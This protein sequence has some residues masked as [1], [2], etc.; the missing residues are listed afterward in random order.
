MENSKST[1]LRRDP[2][3]AG[4]K[5]VGAPPGLRSAQRSGASSNRD[6]GG[7]AGGQRGGPQP[8]QAED[9]RGLSNPPIRMADRL[10]SP[11]RRAAPRTG[12]GVRVRGRSRPHDRETRQVMAKK[13]SRSR[14]STGITARLMLLAITGYQRLLS[15]FLGGHCRFQPSCSRYAKEAIEMHGPMRGGWL[16]FR[17]VTRCRPGG[18][19]GF[20]PV[21]GLENEPSGASSQSRS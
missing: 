17:R 11:G 6:L 10:R 18:G 20:D 7:P 16:A 14:R 15:P 5:R 3:C 4:Q 13:A 21:P 2:C 8:G 19:A 9:P 12:F 1:R